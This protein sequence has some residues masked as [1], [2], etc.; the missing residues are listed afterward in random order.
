[1][2]HWGLITALRDELQSFE[3]VGRVSHPVIENIPSAA[4]SVFTLIRYEVILSMK[5]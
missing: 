4:Q 2:V 5:P 1:M 3:G